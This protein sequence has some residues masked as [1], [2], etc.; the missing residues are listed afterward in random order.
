MIKKRKSLGS[1][2]NQPRHAAYLFLLPSLL[3]LLIFSVIPLLGTFALSLSNIN[4][5]FKN[6]QFIGLDNFVRFLSDSR[7]INSLWHS[8]KF[9]LLQTP[10]QIILGLVIAALLAKNTLFNKFCRSVLYIPVL[11]S[12]ASIGIIWKIILDS[13]IGVVPYFLSQ[14]GLDRINLLRDPN[15]VMPTIAGITSLRSFGITMVILIA[16]LQNVSPALYEAAEMDG[17]TKVQQFVHIT[18]PQV[19]P[20]LGFCILTSFVNSMQVFDQVFVSTGGGPNFKTETAI[21]YI[22]SRGFDAPF[23]L[24]YASAVSTIFFVIIATLSILLN[25][26]TNRKEDALR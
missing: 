6:T 24:G 16:A 25:V 26:Y 10:S 1:F 20:S 11:C 22:Y 12:F 2:W 9:T 19:F 5:F 4:I 21:M 23:E 7:A 14:L 3:I 18:V 17:A 13:N 8:L 15:L